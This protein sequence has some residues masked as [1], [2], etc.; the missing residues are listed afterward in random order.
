[1]KP[2]FVCVLMSRGP[3]QGRLLHRQDTVLA[4]VLLGQQALKDFSMVRNSSGCS[5]RLPHVLSNHRYFSLN[6]SLLHWL[7]RYWGWLPDDCLCSECFTCTTSQF[8]GIIPRLKSPANISSAWTSGK[9][10]SCQMFQKLFHE[11]LSESSFTWVESSWRAMYED[12]P[13]EAEKVRVGHTLGRPTS[14]TGIR[15]WLG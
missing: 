14:W 1:M 5:T 15:V 13:W 12:K 10:L 2:S 9:N 11:Y 4:G 3:S 6:P 8:R 7:K